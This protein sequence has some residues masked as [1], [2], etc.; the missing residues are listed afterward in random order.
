MNDVEVSALRQSVTECVLLLSG[1]EAPAGP[2]NPFQFDDAIVDAVGGFLHRIAQRNEAHAETAAEIE[3]TRARLRAEDRRGQHRQ[4]GVTLP[5]RVIERPIVLG[6]RD[7]LDGSLP[8]SIRPYR[9]GETRP[10]WGL[11]RKS[12]RCRPRP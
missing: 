6:T 2:A 3:D 8:A 11:A 5:Q 1:E 7:R 12:R 4:E 10:N 9:P